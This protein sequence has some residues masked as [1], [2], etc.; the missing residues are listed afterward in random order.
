MDGARGV[1]ARVCVECA[2]PGGGV[3]A[4]KEASHVSPASSGFSNGPNAKK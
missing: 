1:D 3:D 4:A 2:R